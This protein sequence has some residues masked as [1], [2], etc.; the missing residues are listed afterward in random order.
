[1]AIIIAPVPLDMKLTPQQ[2]KFAK[3]NESYCIVNSGFQK[4]YLN[5]TLAV[6]DIS[7]KQRVVTTLSE[8]LNIL[9]I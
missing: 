7:P 9:H 2:K 3:V 1:M 4:C 8:G 5:V 6:V